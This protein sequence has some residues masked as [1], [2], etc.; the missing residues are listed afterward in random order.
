MTLP[1]LQKRL[2][3]PESR[4]RYSLNAM[5]D[6]N[7]VHISGWEQLENNYVQWIPVWAFGAGRNVPPPE[8]PRTTL[9][10]HTEVHPLDFNPGA[11]L[12]A[13]TVIWGHMTMRGE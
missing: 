3:E 5:K 4:L 8:F 6:D 12:Q 11:D 2:G 13:V 10:Q 7:R 9:K 1:D